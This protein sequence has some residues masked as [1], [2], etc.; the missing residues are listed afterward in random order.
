MIAMGV[1]ANVTIRLMINTV[2]FA[3]PNAMFQA[4]AGT[5]LPFLSGSINRSSITS[6]RK[7][8][9]RNKVISSRFLKEKRIKNFP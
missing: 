1:P 6:E 3:I 2:A 4:I 7:L 8:F 9:K 5:G